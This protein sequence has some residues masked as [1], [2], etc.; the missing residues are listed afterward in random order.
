MHPDSI[1]QAVFQIQDGQY[2]WLVMPMGLTNAPSSFQCVIQKVFEGLDFVK[3]YIND[4]LLHSQS[5]KEH[6]VHLQ[7]VFD[8]LCKYKFYLKLHKC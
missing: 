1:E 5:E 3:V 8:R 4:V 2:E 7:K 6:L